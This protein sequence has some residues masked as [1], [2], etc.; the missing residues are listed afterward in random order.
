MEWSVPFRFCNQNIV[1]ISHLC[2]TCSAYHILLNLI[3][4]IIHGE[5]YKL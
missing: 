5:A 2:A 1:Y 3:T 4:L